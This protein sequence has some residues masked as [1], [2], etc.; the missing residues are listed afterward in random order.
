MSGPNLSDPAWHA[1]R[2]AGLM[3]EEL[4]ACGGVVEV[5]G[6]GAHRLYGLPGCK[7]SR[8][9]TAGPRRHGRRRGQPPKVIVPEPLAVTEQQPP[10]P[11]RLERLAVNDAALDALLADTSR[12]VARVQRLLKGAEA[13]RLGLPP[14]LSTVALSGFRTVSAIKRHQTTGR[15]T[16]TRNDIQVLRKVAGRNA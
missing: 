16:R 4:V 1:W 9:E 14:S 11:A 6:R 10:A 7:G 8:S 5:T 2:G 12:V 3:M 13:P 15:G